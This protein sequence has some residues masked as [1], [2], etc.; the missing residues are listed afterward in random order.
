ME[1]KILALSP[2]CFCFFFP[3]KQVNQY[4]YIKSALDSI[5]YFTHKMFYKYMNRYVLIFLWV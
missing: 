2:S 5:K 1:L 3:V 4:A